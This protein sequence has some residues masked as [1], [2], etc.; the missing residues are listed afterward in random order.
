[1]TAKSKKPTLAT[2]RKEIECY[3]SD[4]GGIEMPDMREKAE[5]CQRRIDALG[6]AWDSERMLWRTPPWRGRKFRKPDTGKVNR[7]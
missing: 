5:A 7:G 6:Y 4:A 3:I 2:L 1:M